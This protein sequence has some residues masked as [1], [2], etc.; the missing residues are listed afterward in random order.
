[1]NIPNPNHVT[2]PAPQAPASGKSSF[3]DY[4]AP[5]AGGV[6]GGFLTHHF[7][8][9]G[10]GILST[11]IG[12]GVGAL[13]GGVVKGW[14]APNTSNVSAPQTP[15]NSP[16]VGGQSPQVVMGPYAQQFQAPQTPRVQTPHNHLAGNTPS[17]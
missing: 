11:L 4:A 1:M 3:W 9:E 12:A 5:L 8:G 10:G 7:M 17:H 13:L 16:Y 14:I 2:S 15:G 6:V